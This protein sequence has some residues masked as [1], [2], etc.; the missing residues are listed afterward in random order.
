MDFLSIS[1][2]RVIKSAA[3]EIPYKLRNAKL[4]QVGHLR[5]QSCHGNATQHCPEID[6]RIALEVNILQAMTLPKSCILTLFLRE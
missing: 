1:S 2:D 6:L 3:Q 5:Q 4:H